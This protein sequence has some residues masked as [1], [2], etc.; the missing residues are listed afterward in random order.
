MILS[1]GYGAR[2]NA[3]GYIAEPNPISLSLA[4]SKKN[5]KK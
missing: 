5:I 3:I 2:P 1:A 4:M